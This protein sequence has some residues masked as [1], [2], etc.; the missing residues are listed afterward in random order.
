M[1]TIGSE[2]MVKIV[3]NKHA[4]P[5]R[6]AEFELE[7]GKGIC[8]ASELIELGLKHKLIAKAGGAYYRLNGQSFH[9][10]DAMKIYLSGNEE[11]RL[12]LMAKLREVLGQRDAGR[13]R[14]REGESV[15]TVGEEDTEEEV[16]V[17]DVSDTTDEE[18]VTAI[19]A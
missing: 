9:G 3:K 4:P 17:Y 15:I 6:T 14:E 10:R 16:L 12:E 2:I 19:E 13:K 7:F 1:K 5:F 8:L 18:V 11:A